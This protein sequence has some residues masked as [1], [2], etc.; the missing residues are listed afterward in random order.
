MSLVVLSLE[1]LS[2][3]VKLN[4]S[5]LSFSDLLLKFLL[6]AS[7]FNSQ[8]LNPKVKLLDFS[9]IRPSVLLHREGIF[10]LLPRCQH[11]LFQL[12]LVPVHFEF[13]AVHDLVPLEN[14]VLN[15]VKS[16]LPHLHL[17]L[18]FLLLVFQSADLPL[19]NL[20]QVIF[21]LN[22]FVFRINQSLG[23]EQFVLNIF[24]MLP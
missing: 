23:V 11:P 4:L 2:G 15:V 8:L 6:F 5:C 19:C 12:L 14:L 10:L 3:F 18:Q 21:S 9:L 20:L 22:F 16:L 7:V 1:L 13:E 24:K 17:L